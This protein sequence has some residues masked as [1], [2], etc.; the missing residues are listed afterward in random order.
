MGMLIVLVFLVVVWAAVVKLP[1]ELIQIL[2][3]AGW[4]IGVLS[5]AY[6]VFVA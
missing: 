6:S 2:L 5:I 4:A 3:A 1:G